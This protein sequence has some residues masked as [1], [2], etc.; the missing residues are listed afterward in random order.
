MVKCET[1]QRNIDFLIRI[2]GVCQIDIFRLFNVA[3]GWAQ[4]FGK[5][6]NPHLE[7]QMVKCEFV[8]QNINFLIQIGGV[9]QID[10]S[11]SFNV[12]DGWAQI[13]W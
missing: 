1:V 6:E 2:G 12:A 8:Q 3:G 13:V 4:R 11:R 10:I 5:L 7:Q 9:C